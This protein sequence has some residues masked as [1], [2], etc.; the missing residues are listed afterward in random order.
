MKLISVLF[1]CSGNICRSPIAEGLLRSLTIGTDFDDQLR[2]DSAGTNI[3]NIG[4]NPDS[5]AIEG[6]S[7][8][9]IDLNAIK[10]RPIVESDFYE[11]DFLL[12]MDVSTL[13]VL[14]SSCPIGA[15]G[16]RGLLLDRAENT[17]SLEVKDPYFGTLNDYKRAMELIQIGVRAFLEEVSGLKLN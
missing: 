7:E 12:A 1:V 17:K 9:G 3:T 8:W 4:R 6:A 14:N 5:R 2:V 13:K 11:F 10:A 15:R 16:K